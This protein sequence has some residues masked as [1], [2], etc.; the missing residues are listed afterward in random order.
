MR[1]NGALALI[2]TEAPAFA[3]ERLGCGAYYRAG[4]LGAW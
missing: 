4:G 3:G 1:V 2:L